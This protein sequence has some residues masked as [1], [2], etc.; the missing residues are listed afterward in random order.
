MKLTMRY[1]PLANQTFVK[2]ACLD[3]TALGMESGLILNRQL[4]ASSSNNKHS[5]PKNGRLK[6]K[7]TSDEYGGWM[8]TSWDN[9]PWFMVDFLSNVTLTRVKLTQPDNVSS[10]SVKKFEIDYGNDGVVFE[11]FRDGMNKVM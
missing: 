1:S 11:Y 7:R 5:R 10:L 3:T 2:S 9:D 4:S 8:A 6:F